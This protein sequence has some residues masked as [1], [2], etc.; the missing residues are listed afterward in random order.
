MPFPMHR[1]SECLTDTGRRL[2]VCLKWSCLPAVR[3][4]EA[5]SLPSLE[6]GVSPR[7]SLILWLTRWLPGFLISHSSQRG[8]RASASWEKKRREGALPRQV[9]GSRKDILLIC[10]WDPETDQRLWQV[11]SAALHIIPHHL[12]PWTLPCK[13]LANFHQPVEMDD[14][15]ASV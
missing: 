10:C 15:R 8:Q 5:H 11:S 3:E 9:R 1:N 6:F 12:P 2:S 4:V 7:F 14:G 13:R